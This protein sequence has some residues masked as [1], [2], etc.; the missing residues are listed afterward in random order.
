[1]VMTDKLAMVVFSGTVD[2]LMPVGIIASGAVAMGLDVEVFLTFWGLNSFRKDSLTS[3]TKM[4]RDYEDM[5]PMMMQLMKAKNVPSW[6]DT[7]KKAKEIG[8]VRIHACAMTYDLMNMKKED[9]A[10]IV[11]DVM[12]VGEFV[13]MAKDAK[14]TLFI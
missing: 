1:M 5:A 14:F 2:R 10:D 13:D 9:L 6:F 8:N 12:A 7:L 11:D 3:N 4:S